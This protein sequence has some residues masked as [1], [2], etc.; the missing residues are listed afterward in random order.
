MGLSDSHLHRFHIHGKEYGVAHV[1]GITFT[2]NPER[3]RLADLQLRL[4]ERFLYEYDFYDQWE[5]DVRLEKVLPMGSRQLFPVCTAGQRLAPPEDC[6]GARAFMED[7][8]PRWRQW[9]DN[10]PREELK[11]V[12]ETVQRVFDSGGDRSVMGDRHGL[13][14]ALERVKAYQ[15]RRPDRIHRREINRRLQQYACGD[16]DWLFCETIGE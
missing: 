6:G 9:C 11:L 15:D 4:R 2:D 14:A 3:V 16:R 8:D 12:A 7:G 10:F 5:H 13:I 1:G